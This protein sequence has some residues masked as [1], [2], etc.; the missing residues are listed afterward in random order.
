ME[1]DWWV[2]GFEAGLDARL[3]DVGRLVAVALEATEP[4][5]LRW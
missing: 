1:A 2:R 5:Q 3:P 4:S